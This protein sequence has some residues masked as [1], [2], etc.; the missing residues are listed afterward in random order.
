MARL[1]PSGA[2]FST[3]YEY[4]VTLDRVVSELGL[5]PLTAEQEQLVRDKLGA[6]IGEWIQDGGYLS[7]DAKL[8]TRDIANKL[9]MIALQLEGIF[10]DSSLH[11]G[12]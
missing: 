9:R 10:G 2:T 8:D 1:K 11:V 6:A 3:L 12:R 7:P 5:P 4:E